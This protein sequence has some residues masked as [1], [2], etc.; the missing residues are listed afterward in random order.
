MLAAK[1]IY[2]LIRG[3]SETE[4]NVKSESGKHVTGRINHRDGRK[5]GKGEKLSALKA[6]EGESMGG[7]R[8]I[9]G[10][11]EKCRYST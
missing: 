8:K 1:F 2:G 11:N 7:R 3:E 4:R 9:E 5:G 10:Q 6:D